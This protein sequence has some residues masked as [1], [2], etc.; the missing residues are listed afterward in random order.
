MQLA[1]K[2]GHFSHEKIYL[3]AILSFAC[4]VEGD[5]ATSL[6]FAAENKVIDASNASLE[7]LIGTRYMQRGCKLCGGGCV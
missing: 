1:G 4:G 5:E 7:A 3:L 6:S 2:A